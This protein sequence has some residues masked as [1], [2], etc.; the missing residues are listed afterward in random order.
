MPSCWVSPCSGSSD[1]PW[2]PCSG[3][4]LTARSRRGSWGFLAGAEGTT[5]EWRDSWLASP[6]V[7]ASC[8]SLCLLALLLA[9]I[10]APH[11][12]RARVRFRSGVRDFLPGPG[13]ARGFAG[14]PDLHLVSLPTGLFVAEVVQWY[15]AKPNVL[16][17]EPDFEVR[18]TT[19]PTDPVRLE[20]KSS[21]FATAS[22]GR[23][24]GRGERPFVTLPRAL[25]T[26]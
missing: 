4:S 1:W 3:A 18:T 26:N 5:K 24:M 11:P 14:D 2:I 20:R 19:T 10:A 6:L 25:L 22:S 12:S 8:F 16:Y 7:P 21:R 23:G 9:G 13:T 17:A 15:N